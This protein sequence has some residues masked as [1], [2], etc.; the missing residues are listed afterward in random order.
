MRVRVVVGVVFVLALMCLFLPAANAY[1]DPGSGSL[2]FQAV[3]GGLLA[4][5][6]AFRVFWRRLLGVFG[7][8]RHESPES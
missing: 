1:V 4:A 6:V 8:S 7:K 3:I 5:A 2:I